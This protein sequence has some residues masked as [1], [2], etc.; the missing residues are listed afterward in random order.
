MRS[1]FNSK[2]LFFYF[3][4][5]L[6]AA[7][8]IPASV[9]G[10]ENNRNY[11]VICLYKSSEGATGNFNECLNMLGVPLH[12]LGVRVKYH[13]IEAGIPDDNEMK[14]YDAVISWFGNGEMKNA[15]E[16]CAFVKKT[17]DK[18][19]K[20]I[21][22][23]NFGAYI[24]TAA[25]K[26]PVEMNVLNA[27]FGSAGFKY[28]GN[29]TADAKCVEI[30]HKDQAMCEF[31]VKYGGGDPLFYL[32]FN[33][34][35]TAESQV[36]MKIKRRDLANSSS[37]VIFITPR[38]AMVLNTYAYFSSSDFKSKK[39]RINPLLFLEKALGLAGEIRL[40]TT[41]RNGKRILF[42]H[43]DGDGFANISEIDKKTLCA[44]II[45]E[46]IFKAFPQIKFSV[47]FITGQIDPAISKKPE[48]VDIA[49][50]ICGLDNVEAA[51]HGFSHPH[52]WS[53]KIV[54]LQI[55]GY[56]F[57]YDYEIRLSLDFINKN[58]VPRGKETALM[59]WSGK[60]NP[61]DEAMEVITKNSLLNINGG[62]SKFD[63]TYNSTLFLRPPYLNAGSGFQ[64]L[65]P[66]CNEVIYTNL[67]TSNF[68]GYKK[69]IETFQSTERPRRLAPMD[70]Y[71]HFFSG[72]KSET[73]GALLDVINFALKQDPEVIFASDYIKII[74]DFLT[75]GIV[76]TSPGV[77]EIKTSGYLPSVRFDG[78]GTELDITK[79][80]NVS[81]SKT[82]NGSLYVSL[83][84]SNDHIVAVKSGEKR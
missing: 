63:T 81:G 44:E 70:I 84:G 62:D 45:K 17:T 38:G 78:A 8:F 16:Y 30:E 19:V 13:D 67:F 51:S 52:D 24:D 32:Q 6:L 73:L 57:N 66:A 7:V 68:G 29:W 18:G 21:I 65:T 39:W 22:F 50:S 1:A 64:I 14:N 34:L 40:D 76:K 33:V 48:F 54:N 11:R 56:E 4:I 31:G 23:E 9:V 10:A 12:Y 55:P 5:C 15:G 37:D 28:S 25:G 58:I 69:V 47:S 80:K 42:S 3:F 82:I 27:A 36:F 41:T 83:D 26:K 79:C 71:F 53:K 43:I 75:A 20:Y 60:C 2:K 61:G 72:Q 49:K 77:Y 46:K 35:N 74:N 59:F